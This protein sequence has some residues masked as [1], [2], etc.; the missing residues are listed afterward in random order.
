MLKQV[1][2]A[3]TLLNEKG[4]EAYLV[5]GAVRNLLLNLLSDDYDITTSADPNA[6]KMIFSSYTVYD[7]GKTHGTVVVLIDKVKIDI[8]PFRLED[9]YQDHRHPKKVKFTSSL[10]E[11]LRRR[12]FSINALCMDKDENIIDLFNGLAD[13]NSKT[14]R[15]IGNPDARFHE[16]ALRI[17]R[18][19]RFKA[20]LNFKIEEKTNKA[21]FSNKDLLNYISAERK[22]EELLKLLNEKSAFSIINEYLEVFNIFMP[23][24]HITKETNDFTSSIYALAYLL[25]F[26]DK[27]NLKEL[28]YSKYEIDLIKTLI[29]ATSININSDYEFIKILANIYEKDVL[30]YLQTLHNVSLIERYERLKPYIVLENDLC[31]NGNII[32]EYGYNGEDIKHIKQEILKSIYQQKLHN[33]EVELRTYLKNR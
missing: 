16:D 26:S 11:D 19:I 13:L 4:Y 22:K 1:K 31:I 14:I 3:L 15:C 6:I 18:A 2:E 27:C 5:G 30:T 7:I 24:K 25:S 8:T 17:L 10:K 21:I 9:D 12:D 33:S 20:K 32:K 29:S 28:K 23:F